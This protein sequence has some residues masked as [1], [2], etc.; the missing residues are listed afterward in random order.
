MNPQELAQH[1]KR[2]IK[3]LRNSA[4]AYDQ[5]EHSEAVRIAV[6]LRVL[7]YDKPGSPSLLKFMGKQDTVQLVTTAKALPPTIAGSPLEF[8]ELLGGLVLGETM[9][10]SPISEGSPTLACSEWWNETILIRLKALRK[11]FW[12][13]VHKNAAGHDV[14]ESMGD[15]HFRMLRRLADELLHSPGLL[16][17]M[18]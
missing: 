9:H 14:L 8:G 2:Q 5:G 16:A 7:C 18:T 15:T 12:M 17:L 4:V 10:Y 13:R 3:F 11:G 1:L 6:A